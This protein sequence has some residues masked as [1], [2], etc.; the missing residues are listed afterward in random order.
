MNKFAR[1]L[2]VAVAGGVITLAGAGLAQAET[3]T[4]AAN[5]DRVA[6]QVNRLDEL[7]SLALT[8][9][10][11]GD[12]DAANTAVGDLR[13]ALD[14]LEPNYAD[15]VKADSLGA[16]LQR[17]LPALPGLPSLPS[18]PGVGS[19]VPDL[20]SLTNVLQGLLS[21]VSNLVSSLLG[22]L[23]LSNL[24]ILGSL[25]GGVTGGGN[26]LSAVTGLLGGLTGGGSPL[27]AVTGLLGGL[28]G[29][30][31]SPLS[32]LLGAAGGLGGLTSLLGGGG[33]GNLTGILGG[34]TGGLGG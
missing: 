9:V 19:G 16:E 32:G 15:A 31:G 17:I 5:Q 25:L 13:L 14:E 20:G 33:L 24:P 4:T 27:S 21:T 26:P 29:G 18:L 1:C 11:I 8:G 12:Y 28:T 30:G 23:P 10:Y 2:A 3:S 6:A 34:L 7:S 22:G